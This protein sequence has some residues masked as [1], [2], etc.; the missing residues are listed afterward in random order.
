MYKHVDSIT[1]YLINVLEDARKR[2][3]RADL[4]ITEDLLMIISSHAV[5]ASGDYKTKSKR[6]VQLQRDQPTW[7][8]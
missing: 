3:A 5:I 8:A 2:A 7:G 6:R 1:E 4:P